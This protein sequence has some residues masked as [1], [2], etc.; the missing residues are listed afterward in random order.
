MNTPD[1][2]VVGGGIGGLSAA[3]ALTRQGLTV[4]VLERSAEF[5]EV[6]AGLQ[7][8]PNCT[9]ILNEYGLLDEAKSLGVVPTSMVMRDAVDASEL[10][11]LDL[12]D[13]ERRYGFPYLVIHR[14]DLHGLFLRACERAGVELVTDAK[15]VAY[16]NADTGAQV[17]LSSG[18]VHEA[19][20][21][22]AAD[23]LHSVARKLLIDDEPVSSAYVAYRGTV[24]V[25][26]LA[27]RPVDL[28]EVVVYVGPGHHFVHYGLRGGEM[29]NQVAVF[30]SPKAIA[31]E[32]DW[33]TPD[34]L[35]AAFA[36]SCSEVRE[37]IPFMWRDKWWRMYDRD[38]IM[39]WVSGRIALLGDAAHPPLQY[40]AQGAIMAIE[41]GWVL[42]EH[43]ARLRS[44]DG[45][46]DWDAALAAY[47]AVR[48]EHCRRV[49]TT[50]RVWGEL[51]HLDGEERQ[52]RNL[53]L[54]ARGTQDYTYTDWIYGPTALVPEDEPPLYPIVPLASAAEL[55]ANR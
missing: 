30:E 6:G 13:L 35:D 12:T 48:P 1:V 45:V 54:R 16:E 20:V 10:T 26:D 55:V 3:F 14:S 8:A 43:V 34:E 7:L 47:E 31:G 22:I 50:A 49:L 19:G 17:R 41:D 36:D 28:S 38:P 23:G 9:R 40:M 29:L 42:A 52:Q 18:E 25:A 46:I 2:I 24:P 33:G 4:R 51:W 15:A 5:G 37:G 21:V 27:D 53:L 44:A 39:T 11:K 32:E